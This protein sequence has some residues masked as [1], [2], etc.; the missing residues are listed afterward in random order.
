MMFTQICLVDCKQ[1]APLCCCR[2]ISDAFSDL[3]RQQERL[4][5]EF[6]AVIFDNLD[7]LYETDEKEG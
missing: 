3:A 7:E 1:P 5:P 6:E 2:Q 4:P